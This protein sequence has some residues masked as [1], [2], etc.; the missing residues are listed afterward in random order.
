M[1][2]SVTSF[3]DRFGTSTPTACLPGIG[4]RIRISV[5][6]SAYERSSLSAGDL[7][8]LR[9][10]RELELVAGHARAGDLP[11]HGRLDPELARACATSR[12]AVRAPVSPLVGRGRG[13]RAEERAVGEPVL[14][15]LG[16]DVEHALGAPGAELLLGGG[17][18]P[19]AA[20]RRERL[21]RRRPGR[22]PRRRGAGAAGGRAP[23]PGGASTPPSATRARPSRARGGRSEP[24]MADDVPGP[25]EDRA[26][27]RAADEERAAEQERAADD[28]GAGLTDERG[29]RRRR[30]RARGSR[31]SPC[32]A[33]S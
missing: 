4:A 15:V 18:R 11:G 13:R 9:P 28:R 12:S 21:R 24:A 31:P 10:R 32:R 25:T 3:G 17:R 20:A 22:P 1:S 14:G 27:R 16:D 30:A 5:V 2:P 6:A 26:G 7:R 19:A 33:G 29:E 23:A 8:D